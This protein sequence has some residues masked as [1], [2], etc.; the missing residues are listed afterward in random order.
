MSADETNRPWCGLKFPFLALIFLKQP[1]DVP[2]HL[3]NLLPFSCYSQHVGSQSINPMCQQ[4][5]ILIFVPNHL[6]LRPISEKDRMCDFF[7]FPWLIVFVHG[8]SCWTISSG[9]LWNIRPIFGLNADILCSCWCWIAEV[10][11]I[12]SG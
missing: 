12:L 5:L 3:Q 2:N 8:K 11:G 7:S 10:P 4:K 6:Q 9:N 1:A